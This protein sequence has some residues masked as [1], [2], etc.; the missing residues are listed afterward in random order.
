[1]SLRDP[2]VQKRLMLGLLPIFAAVLYY[3]FLHTPRVEEADRLEMR[4]E[5]LTSQNDAMRAIV[6]RYGSDLERRLAIFQEH[7]SH[8]EQLIPNREDVPV[9]INMIT[10]R[11]YD[12]GV[13]L[14]LLRPGAENPG[15]FYSHQT[16]ELEVAGDY[17]SIGEYLTSIGSL[18]RIVRSSQVKLRRTT[19]AA[20]ATRDRPPVLQ[21]A[22]RIETYV[23]P[24]PGE[25]EA[26]NA[27]G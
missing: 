1:M 15:D 7:V 27:T 16:F 9:L 8:L 17:H 5:T 4:V 12:H 2:Q 20:S 25:L 26:Q 14:M 10:A 24:E 19:E 11:A 13:E 18:P 22:F 23:M 6:A 21:A 3:Q